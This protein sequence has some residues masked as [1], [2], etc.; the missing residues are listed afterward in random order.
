MINS[1][2]V[3]QPPPHPEAAGSGATSSA[4]APFVPPLVSDLGRLTELTLLGGTV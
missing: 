2:S 4:R 3:P 1:S